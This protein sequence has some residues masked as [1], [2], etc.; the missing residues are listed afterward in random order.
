[1]SK[2]V[3]LTFIGNDAS[4]QD[5]LKRVQAGAAKTGGVLNSM[6]KFSK[7][8]VSVGRGLSTYVTAPLAIAGY[9]AVKLAMNYQTAMNR[10]QA[11]TNA[12]AKQV[13]KWGAQLLQMAPQVG[14][15]PTALANSLYYAASAGIPM[16]RVMGVVRGSAKAA[17]MG[18]GDAADVARYLT[19]VLNV[20]GEKNMNVTHGMNALV[21]AVKLGTGEASDYAK[22]LG[23]VISPAQQ[24]GVSLNSLIGLMA[25]ATDAGQDVFTAGTGIRQMLVTLIKPSS[26]VKAGFK[27]VGLSLGGVRREIREKG[28][29]A[30]IQSMI[31][32]THGS[33]TALAQMFP[34]IRALNTLLS[35]TGRHTAGTAKIMTQSMH[36]AGG[37]AKAWAISQQSASVKL[38]KALAALEVVGIKLGNILL[39]YVTKAAQWV[40]KLADKF[41]AMSPRAQHLAIEIAAV[42]AALG[43]VIFL[44]G[45]LLG[46]FTA[47]LKHPVVT[48]IV[49]L[50]A[51]LVV[52]YT[53]SA[54]FRAVVNGVVH[55]LGDMFGWIQRNHTVLLALAAAF[56]TF[57]TVFKVMQFIAMGRAAFQVIRGF[58]LLRKAALILMLPLD[59]LGASISAVGVA[60]MANPLGVIIGVLAAVTIG[61]LIATHHF[62]AFMRVLKSVGTFIAGFF[63]AAFHKIEHVV[64]TVVGFLKKHFELL[65]FLLG[66]AGAPIVAM[67]YLLRH[68]RQI[69]GVIKSVTSS[70]LGW[71]KGFISGAMN[72]ISGAW[73][74]AWHGIETVFRTIWHGIQLFF[75][76]Q[77]VVIRTFYMAQFKALRA[78]WSAMWGAVKT[79]ATAAWHAV[80]AIFQRELNGLE[81]IFRGALKAIGA[82]WSGIKAVVLKPIHELEV[83]LYNLGKS[84]ISGF[85]KGMLSMVGSIAH[86]AGSIAGKTVGFFKSHL[87]INS[88]AKIM[89]P[90][91]MSIT[92]GLAVGITRGQLG[93]ERVITKQVKKLQQTYT[94]KLKS[95]K[96]AKQHLRITE[97]GTTSSTGKHINPSRTALL[98]AHHSVKLARE[99]AR[100][101]RKAWEQELSGNRALNLSRELGAPLLGLSKLVS[102]GLSGALGYGKGPIEQVANMLSAQLKRQ[103]EDSG[104]KVPEAVKRAMVSLKSLSSKAASFRS[105]LID[106]LSGSNDLTQAFSGTTNVGGADVKA[107]LSNQLAKVKRFAADIKILAKKGVPPDFLRQI[108]KGGLDGGYNVAQALV[109][110]SSADFQQILKLQGALS[111]ASTGAGNLA[112][113]TVFGA[114]IGQAAKT[115]SKTENHYRVEVHV[116]GAEAKSARKQ[117]R[118]IAK[119]IVRE[120]KIG[121]R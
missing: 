119:E 82:V 15:A 17:S 88:P 81:S 22:S 33:K 115:L 56:T 65:G 59:A 8:M 49:A 98:S 9:A 46:G 39:P 105:D 7:G 16:A 19:T 11:L 76:V 121:S 50:A 29:W 100:K 89:I 85:I 68:W 43:P 37:A 55:A 64:G 97:A 102:Q 6:G 96:F 5:T 93:L 71:I 106:N 23:R 109:N 14:Q 27:A 30:A 42:A 13:S 60:M 86:A 52:A 53:H 2:P 36:L 90:L 12:S 63:V 79:V 73:S 47:M 75:K 31:T 26:Q 32:A 117:A 92:E 114:G 48:M 40:A 83:L 107:F 99:A 41:G 21:G 24:V 67:I 69:W 94:D 80:T 120:I 58:M 28:V 91:G 54:K 87:H 113:R 78:A 38:H 111:K 4:L 116:S 62:G 70:V 77:W 72:D 104:G 101:A 20:Y 44:S 61:V 112:Q 95:L 10:V 51:A 34:N 1:V 108:I 103:F 35:L 110:S 118:R 18:M 66:P 84:V 57:Y 45:K 25:S 74:A 3:V